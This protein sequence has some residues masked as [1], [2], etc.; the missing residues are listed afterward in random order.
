MSS[1]SPPPVLETSNDDLVPVSSS[2][3][4]LDEPLLRRFC[5]AKSFR[6]SDAKTN[7]LSFSPDG[8]SLISCTD[9]DQISVFDCERG[10]QRRLVNSQKY[11]VDL[12]RFTH[13]KNACVHASTKVDD[14]IRYLSLHDNKFLRYFK[15]HTKRVISL[16]M[17]PADD[18]FMSGSA[19]NT[20][21]LWDLRSPTCSGI[22]HVQGK[23]VL[24]FD[25][26][27]LVFSV[28]VQSEQVKLYDLRS[29]EKGPFTTFKMPRETKCEWTGLRFSPHG[30]YILLTTNGSVM[31]LLDAFDGK[32]LQ[33]FAGHMNN[34][35]V[36]IEGCF[37]PDSKYVISGSSDG[38][39]HA[40]N[41][42]TGYK[43]CVLNGGHIGPVRCV[44]FN[45]TFLMMASACSHMNLWLP[46]TNES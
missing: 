5:V 15:G 38:R 3:V 37:S 6:E 24:S 18:T 31:R 23:P 12:A 16:E 35:G 40:W 34:R 1:S 32:P 28:G 8:L 25:P 11:G 21:R 26:E 36:P 41:A 2:G 22:M 27:G 46:N 19:D 10:V 42:D 14:D 43:V 45:P 4:K 9:D 30:K 17:S 13:A 44:Q 39:V 20:V 29:F 7:S 33:T